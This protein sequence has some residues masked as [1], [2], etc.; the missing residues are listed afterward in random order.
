MITLLCIIKTAV[1]VHMLQLAERPPLRGAA[2][3]ASEAS[4]AL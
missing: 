1:L 3:Q 4:H 2:V